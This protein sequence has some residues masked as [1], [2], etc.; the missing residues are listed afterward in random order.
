MWMTD[1]SEVLD[2]TRI[3]NDAER[4]RS[5][6]ERCREAPEVVLEATHGWYVATDVH[7]SWSGVEPGERDGPADFCPA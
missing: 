5:A 2:S 3:V 6:M 7:S 1:A 4:L